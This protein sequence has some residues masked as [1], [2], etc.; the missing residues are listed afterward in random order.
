MIDSV[1]MPA[2][3]KVEPPLMANLTPEVLPVLVIVSVPVE[4][5]EIPWVEICTCKTSVPP[6]VLPL[7][8]VNSVTLVGFQVPLETMEV[9]VSLSSSF[10]SSQRALDRKRV[11][12]PLPVT[13]PLEFTEPLPSSSIQSLPPACRSTTTRL[14]V[15]DCRRVEC[16]GALVGSRCQPGRKS[17]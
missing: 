10:S 15:R 9:V 4:V 1:P 6:V 16:C 3:V 13:S 7:I 12:K 11:K 17:D 8:G 2:D 5:A 14:N